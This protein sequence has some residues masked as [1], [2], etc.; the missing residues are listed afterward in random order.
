MN[1]TTEPKLNADES[2][3]SRVAYQLWEHAGRPAGRDLEFWLAA[4]SKLRA[5]SSKTTAAFGGSP[6]QET[7]TKAARP[8]R[9]TARKTWPKPYPSLPKF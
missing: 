4:E 6:A 1:K 2:M 5:Q 8:S 3:V 9:G 7:S